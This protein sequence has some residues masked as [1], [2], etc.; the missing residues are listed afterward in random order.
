MKGY[1]VR[2]ILSSLAGEICDSCIFI[3]VA[4]IGAL[5]VREMAIMAVTQVCLKVGYEIVILPLSTLICK[6]VREHELQSS[7]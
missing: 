3:P 4:F 1:G 6:K 5:P 7:R 2:A